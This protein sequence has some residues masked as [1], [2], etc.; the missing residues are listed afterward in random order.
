MASLLH[1]HRSQSTVAD[2]G[3]D[4]IVRQHGFG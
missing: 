1:G 4:C 2:S 3:G